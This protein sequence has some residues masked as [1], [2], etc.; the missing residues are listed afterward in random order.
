MVDFEPQQPIRRHRALAAALVAAAALTIALQAAPAPAATAPG[1]TIQ[2]TNAGHGTV[3]SLPAGIACGSV[4]TAAFQPLSTVTLTAAPAAGYAVVWSGDCAAAT[5]TACTLN[6]TG[7]KAVTVT[8]QPT[9][10]VVY[11]DISNPNPPSPRGWVTSYGVNN[12]AESPEGIDCGDA[13][14]A[15]YPAGTVVTLWPIVLLPQSV[16]FEWQ[17]T[18]PSAAVSCAFFLCVVTLNEPKHVTAVFNSVSGPT[19]VQTFFTV[20][21]KGSG[22]GT[23]SSKP[24]GIVCG[25][26]SRCLHDYPVNMNVRLTATADGGSTFAG[27]GGPCAGA[28]TQRTC[29]ATVGPAIGATATFERATGP[30]PRKRTGPPIAPVVPDS[31]TITTGGTSVRVVRSGSARTIV[32]RARLRTDAT[33]RLGLMRR[34]TAILSRTI[35]A[36]SG[37]NALRLAVPTYIASGSYRIVLTLRNAGQTE[38]LSWPVAL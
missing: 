38:R 1:P 30:P 19:E 26:P 10:T 22:G 15:S 7:N 14:S 18:V 23:V 3:T 8:F 35:A 29:V 24:P 20:T 6:M 13:C 34:R 28:G 16:F 25:P 2:V 17:S 11:K 12:G 27:W 36:R 37:D 5:T 9:L 4:C 32:I 31:R 33:A 21:K